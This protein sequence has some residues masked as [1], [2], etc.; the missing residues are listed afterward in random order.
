MAETKKVKAVNDFRAMSE[1]DLQQKVAELKKQLVEF[2]RSNAANELASSAVIG[3]TR[4][5]IAK[6]LSVLSEK[7][8]ATAE[9]EQ[10]K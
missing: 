5:E 3:K 7:Q 1:K 2:H 8:V 6:A 10:E 9:K 4:K